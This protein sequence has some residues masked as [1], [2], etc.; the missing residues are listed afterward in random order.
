LIRPASLGD[1]VWEDLDVNGS[2]ANENL[3]VLGL[4]GVRVS[5]FENTT[6]GSVFVSD[7]V[8]GANGYYSFTNL[9]PG[10]YRVEVDTSTV[11]SV[12][13]NASTPLVFETTLLSGDFDLDLDFGFFS[14]PTAVELAGITALAD[15]DGVTISWDIAWETDTLGYQL[16]RIAADGTETRLP[17]LVLATGAGSYA[18]QDTDG[19][20]S[21]RYAL[22]VVG[23][24]LSVERSATVDANASQ[25]VLL[26]TAEPF[27]HGVF[28]DGVQI[29]A[30][31]IDGGLLAV[32][33]P[34]QLPQIGAS[35]TP[36]AIPSIDSTTLEG[37]PLLQPLGT[38]VIDATDPSKPVQLVGPQLDIEAGSA[39]YLIA[40]QDADLL[41]R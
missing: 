5:L 35:D 7:T 39:I 12:L 37:T 6:N 2:P 27:A 18:A 1:T 17:G 29:P 3:T 22:E 25:L 41:T 38:I 4:S 19:S 40:P 21:D 36:L 31:A 16:V 14:S 13:P 10:T 24:D 11:P 26:E 8:T 23:T 34:G 9:L 33:T 32:I 28:V 30:L 15:D 20:A